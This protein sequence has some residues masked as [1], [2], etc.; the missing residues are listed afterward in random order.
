MGSVAPGNPESERSSSGYR[1]LNRL[2]SWGHCGVLIFAL[3]CGALPVAAQSGRRKESGQK[4]NSPQGPIA[5]PNRPSTA[6]A[7][8]PTAKKDT[9]AT[10]S[11]SASDEVEESDVVRINSNLV[12][13]PISVFL[14]RVNAV[15]TLKLED[16][17]L[18]VDGQPRQISDMTRAETNV[19]MAML[20][21]N[22]GTMDAAREF[23]KKAAM[24]FFRRVMRP[25]DEAAIYSVETESYLV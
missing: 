17:E 6:P 5:D 20:F 12:P 14:V 22:S 15:T 7:T 1:H 13:I 23:E 16:F 3:L 18:R 19:R 21:D 24:R 8:T 25:I 4:N 9:S 11:R 10:R 2:L